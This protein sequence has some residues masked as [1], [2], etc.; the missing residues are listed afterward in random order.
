MLLIKI[1]I[2]R[3]AADDDAVTIRANRTTK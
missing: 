3:G 1:G 2:N